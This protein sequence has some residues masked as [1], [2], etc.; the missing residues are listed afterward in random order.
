LLDI[1]TNSLISQFLQFIVKYDLLSIFDDNI[2][3]KITKL[4]YRYLSNYDVILLNAKNVLN[5]LVFYLS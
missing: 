5:Y 1:S 2:D 3:I 4:F